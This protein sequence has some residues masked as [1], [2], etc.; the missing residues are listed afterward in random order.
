MTGTKIKNIIF[1]LGRVI[2]NVDEHLTSEAFKKLGI[3]DFNEIYSQIRQTSL[4]DKLEK[5]SITTDEFRTELKKHLPNSVND[6]AIDDAWNAMLLDLPRE[7]IHLLEQLRSKYQL[8]LLSN[9]NEIHIKAYSNI[10]KN[11]YG[12][13][14]L[15]HLFEKEYYSCKIGLRKPDDKIF[16][17]VLSENG[18]IPGETLFVD[19]SEEHIEA[20]K[21]LGIRTHLLKKGD[22]VLDISHAVLKPNGV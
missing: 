18:L 3:N 21:K 2:L 17:L 1:D 16:R 8:F 4:F 20:A 5:G 13:E 15:S 12:F 7:R 14:N 11:S 22:S 6:R 19:D 10:L 9:T